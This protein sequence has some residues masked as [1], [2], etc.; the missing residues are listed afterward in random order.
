V[1]LLDT[2]ACIAAMRGDARMAARLIQHGG[3]VRVPFAVAAELLY[4]IEK[5]VRLGQPAEA[6]R[7]RLEEFLKTVG[8]IALVTE[9]ALACYAELRA[10]LEIAGAQIGPNDLW[11]AA[12]AVAED[13]LLVSA[14]TREF[15]RVPGLRL[16]NWLAR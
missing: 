13:A 2:N 16:E 5:L 3:R 8:A 12:Q 11:I 7:Q 1:I 6:A 9:D 4:G 14:N 15:S 10:D